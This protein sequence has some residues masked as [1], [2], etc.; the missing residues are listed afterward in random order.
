MKKDPVIEADRQPDYDRTT[1]SM[2]DRAVPD[3]QLSAKKIEIINEARLML[4]G[5]DHPPG[6][7]LEL[8]A[9]LEEMDQF[10][11]A[12]DLLLKKMRQ[13]QSSGIKTPLKEYQQLV[14]YT[15]KDHSLPASLKFR[16]ALAELKSHE[17]LL[18][19][20]DCESLGL[21]GSVYRSMWYH[22]HQFRNL[23]IAAFYFR[24]GFDAWR[25][26]LQLAQRSGFE[27]SNDQGSCAINLAFVEELMAIERL[28][29]TGRIVDVADFQL[30]KI[31]TANGVR[32]FI[33]HQFLNEPFSDEPVLKDPDSPGG[34]MAVIA[35]AYFGLRKYDLALSF[36]R[37]YIHFEKINA[38]LGL[39]EKASGVVAWK[40][41]HFSQQI[42]HLAYFQ[43]FLVRWVNEPQ[44]P[45]ASALKTFAET[46]DE[47]KIQPCLS[48]LVSI[49]FG[50]SKNIGGH[51]VRREGRSGLAL[52]GGGFRASLF[53][54]GA[55]AAL[56][57]QNRLKDLEVISCVSGGS[58]LGAFYYLKLK[59]I[60]ETSVDDE[61]G[62]NDYVSMI[63]E[64][65]EEFLA[66]IQK[67]LRMRVF[68]SFRSTVRMMTD[69]N[70]SRTHRLGELYEQ[71][72]YQPLLKKALGRRRRPSASPEHRGEA[73]M[74]MR[75][76]R[77]FPK[78]E[79]GFNIGTDNWKRINKV[80]QLILNATSVNTGHN[81]QFTATFMGE[82]PGNIL[83]DIDVKPRLRRMYYEDAPD[84]YKDFR[85]GYAVSASSCVPLM[86]HP[87]PL[88]GLY[89][90]N[91]QPLQLQLIDGGL[92]DNQGIAALLEQECK[93]MFISD[94]SGQ[95][96][97]HHTATDNDLQVFYRAD[98]ILQER[99][100][101]LQ[102][103]DIRERRNTTQLHSVVQ[104]HLKSEL[105]SGPLSWIHCPDP[106]RKIYEDKYTDSTL[107]GYGILRKM[108]KLLSE[109]RTDL[110]AFNDTEAYALMYSG[111]R[112][113]DH[114]LSQQ[115][116]YDETKKRTDWRFLQ[117]APFM[118]QAKESVYIER[119]LVVGREVAMKVLKV[120]MMSKVLA[121]FVVS[122]VLAGVIS[123]SYLNWDRTVSYNYF[124][125]AAAVF[126]IGLFSK[127]AASVINYRNELRK[128][129]GILGLVF[130]GVL[131]CRIYLA[132]FNRLYLRAGKV[133]GLRRSK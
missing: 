43:Q 3:K 123:W 118:T 20:R 40:T 11:Y 62:E 52:S 42:F 74:R 71:Y 76:L 107:L 83:T 25:N 55:L 66:G 49:S 60:L 18:T 108:Q 7:I 17:D 22:D 28:E 109:I 65:E 16:E 127:F 85:L 69:K 120:S 116:G 38:E 47:N 88:Y 98:N 61:I 51:E 9:R 129:L 84:A 56:A 34:I 70:Y 114:A 101:E 113:M 131:A 29:Q 89:E 72:L 30:T 57:E 90:D 54:I 6:K 41:R 53:H 12:A 115:T 80:P 31:T 121:F 50:R 97:T 78:G 93:T 33:L 79:A 59:E 87:M 99:L 5:E 92:H 117:I 48:E 45:Q 105:A 125:L 124:I 103:Q 132:F 68:S 19:T 86:F 8:C 44:H 91:G 133:S 100:R 81:W 126:V 39:G 128:K 26:Y 95:M 73:P 10:S 75:D 77:I 82:P 37:R 67:N 32:A 111:Y 106:T 130:F 13:D 96:P 122:V 35:E 112:Q 46:I 23:E 94:A 110:D 14:R 104:I 24:K 2:S 21:A 15:Y 102:F 27:N 64:I 36:I 119:L 1:S 63:R 4:Q 58:I